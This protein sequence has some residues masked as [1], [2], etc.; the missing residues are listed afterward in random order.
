MDNKIKELEYA[1]SLN[2]VTLTA[3]INVLIEKD[4]ISRDDIQT[5]FENAKNLVEKN[6]EIN[7]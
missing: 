3:L 7:K 5:A 2:S 1:S 4:I 6:K